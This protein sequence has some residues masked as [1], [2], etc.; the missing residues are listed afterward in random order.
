M[1]NVSLMYELSDAF[2]ATS[3]RHACILF[4]LEKFDKLTAMPWYVQ[5]LTPPFTLPPPLEK[6]KKKERA[7]LSA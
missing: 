1:E 7:P 6:R 5:F 4:V 3:L 2:N